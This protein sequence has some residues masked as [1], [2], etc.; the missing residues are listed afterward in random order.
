[1]KRNWILAAV[2]CLLAA[3]PSFGQKKK[4]ASKSSH[5]KIVRV[6]SRSVSHSSR[7]SRASSGVSYRLPMAIVPQENRGWMYASEIASLGRPRPRT[8][9]SQAEIGNPQ[10]AG[11]LPAEDAISSSEDLSA[12]I[13]GTTS[14]GVAQDEQ[15]VNRLR[16]AA[17]PYLGIPYGAARGGYDCSGFVRA[18]LNDFGVKLDG[19]SSSDFYQLGNSVKSPELQPGDLVFFS[20]N[21]RHIGHVGV[22]VD[23]GVFVHSSLSRGITYSRLDEA[24]YARRYQGARRISTIVAGLQ[25]NPVHRS[26]QTALNIDSVND[27]DD[28][29]N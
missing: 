4:H 17:E 25:A 12:G 9:Y 29:S 16:I 24:W 8:N 22:Y 11:I 13:E 15:A 23:S 26:S 19:S 7:L 20:T 10:S 3:I 14:F 1:M 2:C 5:K 6:T 18:I 28:V 27:S 21:S